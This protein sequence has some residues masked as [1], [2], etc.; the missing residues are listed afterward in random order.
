MISQKLPVLSPIEGISGRLWDISRPLFQMNQ[1]INPHG[2]TVLLDAILNIAGERELNKRDTLE[3]R[4]V[5]IIKE[6]TGQQGTGQFMEWTIKV[7]DIRRA[8]NENRAEDHH[9]SPQWIGKKLKSMSLKHRTVQGRSEII[10]TSQEYQT[11]LEQY[12]CKTSDLSFPPQTLPEKPVEYQPDTGM[13]GS[14]RVSQD[15]WQVTPEDQERFEDL[16]EALELQGGLSHQE[17]TRLAAK[18]TRQREK[19]R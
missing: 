2:N 11:L 6:L 3:G 8:F 7:A 15:D 16:V 10:L 17:A 12:G 19:G 14:C 13:V 1:L 18:E 9:V 5:A 4:L